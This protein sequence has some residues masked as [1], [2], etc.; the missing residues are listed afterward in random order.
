MR[1]LNTRRG[2][3]RHIKS[4]GDVLVNPQGKKLVI[5]KW[6]PGNGLFV[7]GKWQLRDERGTTC[8]LSSVEL[9]N[10]GYDH[11]K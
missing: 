1:G 11:I 6:L 7:I 4:T 10:R 8:Q 9:V 5:T 3:L 2:E